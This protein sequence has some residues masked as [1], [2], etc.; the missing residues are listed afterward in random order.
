MKFE[1]KVT[2]LSVMELIATAVLMINQVDVV[3]YMHIEL[4]NT[5]VSRGDSEFDFIRAVGSQPT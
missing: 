4:A 5:R 3:C 1:R 2:S